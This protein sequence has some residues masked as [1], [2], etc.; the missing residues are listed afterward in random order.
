MTALT[1]KD[2]LYQLTTKKKYV[3]GEYVDPAALFDATELSDLNCRLIENQG[4]YCLLREKK[5]PANFTHSEEIGKFL[6]ISS[7][8]FNLLGK[9]ALFN[10]INPVRVI[11]VDTETTG[12]AGGTGTYIFLIGLGFFADD[13]FHIK[14]ILLPDFSHELALL[15][16][17]EKIIAHRKAII[18]F[19]GKS[20]DIPLLKTRFLLHKMPHHLP[21]VHLDLLHT[22]RRL[23]KNIYN[24]CSLQSL[25]KNVLG[26]ARLGDVE[27]C[28]IPRIYFNFLRDRRLAELKT[29]FQ[30][31]AI[32]L[33]S[34]VSISIKAWRA[35][36]LADGSNDICFDRKG[37]ISSLESL[38][39]FELAAEKCKAFTDSEGGSRDDYFLLKQSMNLKK[40]GKI[41]LAADLWIKMI[42][43]GNGFTPEGY[44]ELA[45]YYE[46]KMRDYDAALACVDKLETRLAVNRELGNDAVDDFILSDL[47]LRKNRI[48]GKL[49]KKACGKY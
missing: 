15:L 31:N 44:I 34:L 32:D 11:F 47:Q 25:E 20:Y 26:F 24:E 10:D 28:E 43:N 36:S 19:N 48:M 39:L 40:A 7:Q 29:I 46:H 14:Q 30:H 18:S 22:S 5:F 3:V 33:L 12:L 16:E 13:A 49:S 23:W 37:V 42:K 38:K 4:G 8:D 2:K 1:I 6:R 17:L 45:K 35:F 9:A 27:S 41:G 21:N